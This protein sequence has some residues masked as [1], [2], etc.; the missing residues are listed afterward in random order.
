MNKHKKT[1]AYGRS[2]EQWKAT[3]MAVRERDG[4]T[5]RKCG[6][7][8]NKL[9]PGENLQCHHIKRASLGGTNVK[10]NLITLCSTCHSKEYGSGHARMRRR[11]TK[12]RYYKLPRA[13]KR[14]W[15]V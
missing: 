10:R 13:F 4:L 11:D 7:R 5:C 2:K 15:N 6:R 9:K 1:K 8:K 14:T 3:S 12:N